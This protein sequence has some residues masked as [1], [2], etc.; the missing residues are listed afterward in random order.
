MQRWSVLAAVLVVS[1]MSWFGVLR[2][3]SAMYG[4]VA[5]LDRAGELA[6]LTPRPQA[7]IV[8]DRAGQPAFSFFV[9]RRIDIPLES[10]SPHMIDALLAV[11][12]RRFYRHNG[13]DVIRVAGAAW[14]NWQAGRIVQGGST[15][16]QQLARTSQ[17]TP[18]R[19]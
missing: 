16:T 14:K 5:Q 19:T 11:E 13:I 1:A 4:V 17:L 18:E 6:A 3:A 8:F 9:E 2:G 10:V 7:T 15:L 12:D